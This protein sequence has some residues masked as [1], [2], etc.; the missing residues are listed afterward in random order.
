MPKTPIAVLGIDLGKNSCSLA[1]LDASGAVVFRRKLT[2]EGVIAFTAALPRC[3]VAMEA[4][5]GP[6]VP[7]PYLRGSRPRGAADVAGV[8]AALREGAEDR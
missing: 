1:G 3:V 8:R 5:C 6:Y 7:G 2:R 4:C